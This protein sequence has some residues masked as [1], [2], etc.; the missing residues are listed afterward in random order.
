MFAPG[1]MGQEVT[2]APGSRGEW[3]LTSSDFAVRWTTS[4]PTPRVSS[5]TKGT[6]KLDVLRDIV[7]AVMW[8]ESSFLLYQLLT[9]EE[10]QQGN[11]LERDS[12]EGTAGQGD[13]WL[14]LR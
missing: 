11:R 6:K 5:S 3:K 10:T 13:R 12:L 9:S 4:S 14:R 1:H 2:L 7:D 8:C